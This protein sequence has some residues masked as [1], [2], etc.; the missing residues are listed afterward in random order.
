[1]PFA[2]DLAGTGLMEALSVVNPETASV[3]QRGT[4]PEF[5]SY[6]R[7]LT[8]LQGSY[9]NPSP[10]IGTTVGYVDTRCLHAAD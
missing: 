10:S 3:G 6:Q 7:T 9:D 8:N 1:M 4:P 5:R 2:T